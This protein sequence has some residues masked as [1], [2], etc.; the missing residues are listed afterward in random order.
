MVL[1]LGFTSPQDILGKVERDLNDLDSAIAAQ[2]Q[3]LIC[4]ALC[5]FSV[6]ITSVK[7]WLKAHSS[8]SYTLKQVE[9]LVAGSEALSSFR[10]IAKANKHRLITRYTPTTD[11][12]LV[13]IPSVL[14]ASPDAGLGLPKQPI[15]IKIIRTDGARLD[16]GALARTAFEELKVFMTNHGV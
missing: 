7:D 1:S 14:F 3:G 13:S 15:R 6:S 5:D 2:D 12:T 4:D 11:E 16:A 8:S 9:V 10:D